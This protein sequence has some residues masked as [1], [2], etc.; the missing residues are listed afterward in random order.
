MTGKIVRRRTKYNETPVLS[1]TGGPAK[2]AE[3]AQP[4][5]S[6]APHHSGRSGM[7]DLA[8]QIAANGEL[9]D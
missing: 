8:K 1:L 5:L 2:A 4:L 3:I 7:D 9:S 6:F